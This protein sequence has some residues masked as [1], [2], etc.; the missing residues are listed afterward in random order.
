MIFIA[1]VFVNRSYT[2]QFY[3]RDTLGEIAGISLRVF[4]RGLIVFVFTDSH[5]LVLKLSQAIQ[6]ETR[7]RSGPE[8]RVAWSYSVR[9]SESC[10]SFA[11]TE[12]GNERCETYGG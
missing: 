10:A 8:N 1:R 11:R 4:I 9:L 2:S 7:L 6:A 5:V 12:K 3:G